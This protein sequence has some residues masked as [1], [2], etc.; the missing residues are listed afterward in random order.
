LAQR[1]HSRRIHPFRAR[2][3]FPQEQ[4]ANPLNGP[5]RPF[6]AALQSR[7]EFPPRMGPAIHRLHLSRR[8]HRPI[9]R[10]G[11]GVQVVW[12]EMN[13]ASEEHSRPKKYGRLV[14]ETFELEYELPAC[15]RKIHCR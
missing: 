6:I 15:F 1:F 14:E 3:A 7:D 4:T 10:V 13:L 2:V 12:K 8:M 5:S 9:G 11:V